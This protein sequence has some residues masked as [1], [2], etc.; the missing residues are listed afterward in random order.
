MVINGM[1]SGHIIL[2][3]DRLIRLAEIVV[4]D[5]GLTG[6]VVLTQLEGLITIV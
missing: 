6:H 5:L 1:T 3:C 4:V 2:I